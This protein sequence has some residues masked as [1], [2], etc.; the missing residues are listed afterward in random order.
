MSLPL[1]IINPASAGGATGEAWPGVASDLARH[2]GPFACAFTERG[3]DARAIA[4]REA[5]E[6]RSLIVACGGDGTVNEVADGILRS[7]ADAEL[8]L[9]PSGTG[10]DF[11]RT[12][13]IPARTSDAARVLREGVTRR[14][15]AGRVEF[16][17]A[18]GARVSRHFINVASFGM[19]VDVIGRV[20]DDSGWLATSAARALGGRAAFAVAAMQSAFAYR[21]PLVR[22][23]LD[24]RAEFRMKI[25]NFCVANARYFGGGMKIAPSARLDDGLF[26][27][28][29][30]GDMSAPSILANSYRVYLGTHL[31]LR[32]VSHAHARRVTAHAADGE[33]GVGLE[34]DG[35]IAGRLPA[36]FEVL[37]RALSVRCP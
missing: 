36:T 3:G 28:V 19:G 2:F 25:T 10:G 33:E 34:I 12:L 7:G 1:V 37:P 22:I 8:G 11:R 31:G 29:A 15:D 13:D 26:D 30:V 32:H 35:D 9:L 23:S 27:V 18:E 4:E 17:D 14:I 24:G 16:T 20:K 6:G 21:Q 5:A